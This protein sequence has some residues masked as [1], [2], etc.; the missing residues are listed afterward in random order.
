MPDLEKLKKLKEQRN[1]ARLIDWANYTKD[2]ITS[3]Q[4]RDIIAQ[5][6]YDLAEYLYETTEWTK[7][8]S[9]HSGRRLPR[10]GVALLRQV[11]GMA[12]VIGE[13][14][15]RP[16]ADSVRAYDKFGD[17]D[18]KTRLLYF[19]I[20]FDTLTRM[21]GIAR[22]DLEALAKEKDADISKLARQALK[23]LPEDEDDEEDEWD[24]WDDD[25]EDEDDDAYDDED[26][27]GEHED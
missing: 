11:T 13:P 23:D 9:G 25:D 22:V 4:A 15:L 3:R 6:P 17:P 18:I 1:Y 16:L 20:V 27:E 24:E 14:M 21:G 5:D 19:S 12:V 8:N 26:D 7:K 2:P 10:R